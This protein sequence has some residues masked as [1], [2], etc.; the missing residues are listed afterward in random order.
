MRVKVLWKKTEWRVV[1]YEMMIYGGYEDGGDYGAVVQSCC[2]ASM[3]PEGLEEELH[4]ATLQ[5]WGSRDSE[6]L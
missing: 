6:Q 5:G 3:L 1:K 4:S 2:T